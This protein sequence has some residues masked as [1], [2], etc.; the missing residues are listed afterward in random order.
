MKAFPTRIIILFFLPLV[1]A[2]SPIARPEQPIN[3]NSI[4]VDKS[5]TVGQTFVARYDGL[6]GIDLLLEPEQPSPVTLTLHLKENPQSTEDIAVAELPLDEVQ[7]KGFYR[8][9]FPSHQGKTANRYYYLLLSLDG[10]GAIRAGNAPGDS[11]LNGALYENNLPKDS[12]LTFHL[13]YDPGQA[14]MGLISEGLIWILRIAI[15]FFIFVLP[16]WALVSTIWPEWNSFHWAEKAAISGGFS[17]AIY[18]VLFLWTDL[19]GLH[20]GPLY[21]WLP[22]ILAIGILLWRNRNNIARLNP[23]TFSSSSA[24]QLF[25]LHSVDLALFLI[26]GLIFATRFWVIRNLD[27]P[28]WGDSYHHTMIAQLLVD[29]GGLFNSW[30]P[31]ADLQTLTYHF[32]F[33]TLVACFHWITRL[34]LP[35]STL[36]TGQILNA[37]SVIALYPLATRVGRN[38]WAGTAVLLFAGLLFPMPMFYVNWGRY[39]QLTGQV[40]LPIAI[41]FT[42]ITLESRKT[43][44]RSIGLACIIFTGLAL[45]HYKVLLFAIPFFLVFI[46]LNFRQIQEFAVMKKTLWVGTG[47]GVLFLPW[48]I[49]VF[50]GK[51]P[52]L[53]AQK[54]AASASQVLSSTSQPNSIGDLF[55]YLPAG[56]WFI[57]PIIVGWGLWRREKSVGLISLWWFLIFL[58]ANPQWLRLPGSGVINNFDVLI[59]WYIPAGVIMGGA[60]GWIANGWKEIEKGSF[61][62]NYSVLLLIIAAGIGLWGARQR[63]GD[64]HVAQYSLAARP[65]MRAATWI[66]ENTPPDALFLVNSFLAYRDTTAVGSDGGWWLPLIA[67]RR[68]TLPPIN[69]GTEQIPDPDFRA[70]IREL[71]TS[72]QQKG[73][74]NSD[75]I[76]L[77]E[78]WGVTYVYIGQQQGHVN[79]DG[80]VI[81][82]E[83]M[84][85]NP[86]NFSLSYHQDRTWVFQFSP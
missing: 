73:V 80:P 59:A 28:M 32:G 65:D 11:Y 10:E 70:S 5:K 84:L 58:A 27:L 19:V 83:Q 62:F 48:F 29:N 42:W 36:W 44:W 67:L 56:I 82:P 4:S 24:K 74:A 75:V 41:L 34:S 61:T 76:K 86:G 14:F 18:P 52:S 35:Q 51:L 46:V 45:T 66:E 40:I 26:L 72:I 16:G 37:L 30:Q 60:T 21:A 54:V 39:T 17:L 12:Q 50:M 71:A 33:H 68:T 79:Y 15:G 23:R 20:L 57:L 7:K 78:Q 64:L 81:E 6:A 47:A 77:L 85:A 22:P 63:L 43:D 49:H 8:F 1:A 13:V 3:T 9:A 69:Y 38:Q 2:C 55:L 25:E 53:Y 31:Y